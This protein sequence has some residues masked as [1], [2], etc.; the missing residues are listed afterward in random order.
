MKVE[1]SK[2]SLHYAEEFKRIIDN[3][4]ITWCGGKYASRPIPLYRIKKY[5]LHQLKIK[6]YYEFA[7]LFNGKFVGTLSIENID[8]INK[9]ASIG[10]WIAKPYRSMGIATKAVK[11]AVSFGFNK[12]K[13]KKIYAEVRKNNVPSYKVLERTGFKREGILRKNVFRNGKFYDEYYYG[14]LR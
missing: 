10:Y 1:I 2:L 6:N 5:I 14:I 4:E 3:K 8:K 13:L 9:H 11:L 12:L 7:I